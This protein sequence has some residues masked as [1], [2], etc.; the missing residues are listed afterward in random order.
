MYVGVWPEVEAAEVNF[1]LPQIKTLHILNNK[2]N[3]SSGL[4]TVHVHIAYCIYF[5]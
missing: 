2:M 5:L 3:I 4:M 1:V